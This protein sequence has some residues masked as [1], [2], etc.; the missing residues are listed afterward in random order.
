[1]QPA[2]QRLRHQPCGAD[3]VSD[4]LQVVIGGRNKYLINGHAAQE[5]WVAATGGCSC[6]HA[7]PAARGGPCRNGWRPDRLGRSNPGW[8][9]SAPVCMLW[10]TIHTVLPR[11]RRQAAW[12]GACTPATGRRVWVYLVRGGPVL[13]P[14]CPQ[15]RRGPVPVRAAQRQQPHLPHHA[16]PHHQGA[17]TARGRARGGAS[18]RT[19]RPWKG[20][21]HA[22][23]G[24][25]SQR[26]IAPPL[27]LPNWLRLRRAHTRIRA[28]CTCACMHVCACMR[29]QVLNMKPAEILALLEEASGTKMFEKKKQLSQKTLE[30]KEARLA[31]I[32]KVRARVR[33]RLY[34]W[35]WGVRGRVGRAAWLRCTSGRAISSACGAAPAAPPRAAACRL[36]SGWEGVGQRPAG[37]PNT[38]GLLDDA[39]AGMQRRHVCRCRLRWN[40]SARACIHSAMHGCMAPCV[41]AWPHAWLYCR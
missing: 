30:K 3:S 25:P 31:E 6:C 36:Q 9:S 11:R 27:P 37:V 28:T 34:V 20:M 5:K 23:S 14:I 40:T 22:G 8:S 12:R 33:M 7:G 17:C 35:V 18:M 2:Q 19:A 13:P 4:C 1:M 16:R 41:A 29:V 24:P 10:A 32:D 26:G 39:G 21:L 15:P 38:P